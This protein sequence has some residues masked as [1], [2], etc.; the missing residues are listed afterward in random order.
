MANVRWSI[1]TEKR[2]GQ[3]RW[4]RRIRD[5]HIIGP[6]VREN[7]CGSHIRGLYVINLVTVAG[8]GAGIRRWPPKITRRK[9]KNIATPW[10]ASPETLTPTALCAPNR[11]LLEAR[12]VIIINV[13]VTL[14]TRGRVWVTPG[15]YSRPRS[16]LDRFG[17]RGE[18]L[19]SE[20]TLWLERQ[21][22]NHTIITYQENEK[23]NIHQE[24]NNF[25]S[26][27]KQ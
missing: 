19:L 26:R 1:N 7:S 16:H 5:A 14:G 2:P 22:T 23:K 4:R 6:Y 15:V 27:N 10:S 18:S 25:I 12:A 3:Q 9:S 24:R 8:C 13:G 21:S 20:E 11:S 17:N